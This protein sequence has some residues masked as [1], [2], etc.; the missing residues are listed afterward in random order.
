[1]A[2]MTLPLIG[3][4]SAFVAESPRSVCEDAGAQCALATGVLGVC[5]RAACDAGADPP[6]YVCTPQ[7]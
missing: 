7:H 3:C 6:C 2:L 4:D 1:M 5:E